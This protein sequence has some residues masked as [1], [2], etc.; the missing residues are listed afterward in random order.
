M[1]P[2]RLIKVLIEAIRA[3]GADEGPLMAAAIAYYGLFSFV[4]LL[5]VIISVISY[6]VPPVVLQHQLMVLR[7]PICLFPPG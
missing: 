6:V 1:Q 4:P 2:F 5:L 7:E 3:Y